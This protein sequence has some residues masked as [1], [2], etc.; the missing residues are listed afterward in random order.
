MDV[1]CSSVNTYLVVL[2]N[3][4]LLAPENVKVT[5]TKDV[6][7]E[8]KSVLSE[9]ASKLAVLGTEEVP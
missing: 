8:V 3:V 1:P 2:V 9:V 7:I 6:P 4:I 5:K